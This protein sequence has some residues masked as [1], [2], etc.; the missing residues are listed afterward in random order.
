MLPI[1][2]GVCN[3]NGIGFKLISE[4]LLFVCN[5]DL[6][7]IKHDFPIAFEICLPNS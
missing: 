6:K 2:I 5:H 3:G 1:S 4:H 7:D